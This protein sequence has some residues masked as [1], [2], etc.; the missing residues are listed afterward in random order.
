MNNQKRI[1]FKVLDGKK[2]Y[3]ALKKRRLEQTELMRKNMAKEA[4][5]DLLL[6]LNLNVENPSWLQR[7]H[8]AWISAN[9][10]LWNFK[11]P[12]WYYIPTPKVANL[13]AA[14]NWQRFKSK[15]KSLFSYKN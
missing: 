11:I 3:S 12:N 1:R 14:S 5:A 2:E 15:V 13:L 10:H 7:E 9:I 6:F 4:L 8:I